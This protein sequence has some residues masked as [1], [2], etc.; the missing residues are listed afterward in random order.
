MKQ[1]L[2]AYYV[3]T[4]VLCLW[5]LFLLLVQLFASAD[6]LYLLLVLGKGGA[7]GEVDE[8]S[9]ATGSQ[10]QQAVVQSGEP[11]GMKKAQTP[12]G[13]IR[14][15][16]CLWVCQQDRFS[17]L[18][19]MYLIS[20][21]LVRGYLFLRL[22][23]CDGVPGRRRGHTLLLRVVNFKQDKGGECA[24]QTGKVRRHWVGWRWCPLAAGHAGC[25]FHHYF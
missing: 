14:T 16:V 25:N 19:L 24:L 4:T 8:A 10:D 17:S 11:R 5:S 12:Q 20:W 9:W 22:H 23:G 6:I 21:T 15:Q 1:T 2:N 3:A 13:H 7:G 18:G